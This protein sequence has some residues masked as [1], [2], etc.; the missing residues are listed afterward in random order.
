MNI[1]LPNFVRP[2]L[3]INPI[4]D[5]TGILSVNRLGA[6]SR[7]WRSNEVNRP[8]DPLDPEVT[9]SWPTFQTHNHPSNSMDLAVKVEA[10]MVPRKNEAIAPPK[11]P[12]LTGDF[13]F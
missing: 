12:A 9:S 4:T 5:F 10:E 11:A 7:S 13:R 2:P 3:L 1:S 8:R 6:T